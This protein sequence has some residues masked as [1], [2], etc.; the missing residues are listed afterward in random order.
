MFKNKTESSI[1]LSFYF[2]IFKLQILPFY[3]IIYVCNKNTLFFH[4][5]D[6]IMSNASSG[7]AAAAG[8]ITV[9]GKGAGTGTSTK[10]RKF[11]FPKIKINRKILL[12]Y[13]VT[14]FKF[15]ASIILG[16]IVFFFLGSL[17]PDLRESMPHFY[18]I[19]D[20]IIGTFDEMCN[21][22]LNTPFMG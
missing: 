10:K 8:T 9:V 6:F 1:E 18:T 7:T 3:G 21:Y 17:A 15:V 14:A 19:I 4:K 11:T 22:I 2:Y 20:A 13:L 5:E 12:K 16:A